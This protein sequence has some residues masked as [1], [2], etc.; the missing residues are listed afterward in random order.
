MMARE[1]GYYW[2]LIGFLL[3]S[4]FGLLLGSY[5]VL[6]GFFFGVLIG[7]LLGSCGLLVASFL[8]LFWVLFSPEAKKTITL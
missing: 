7:F 6:I 5:W 3:G 4:L 1:G 8:V 2:V